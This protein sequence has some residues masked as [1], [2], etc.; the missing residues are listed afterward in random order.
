[1]SCRVLAS[2]AADAVHVICDDGHHHLLGN[3]EARRLYLTLGQV[4]GLPTDH[5]AIPEATE[6]PGPTRP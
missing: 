4:L 6:A 3:A 1:M 2:G 5:V